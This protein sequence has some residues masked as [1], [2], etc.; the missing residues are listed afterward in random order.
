[1]FSLN[2]ANSVTKNCH[3]SK[4]ARNWPLSHLLCK[5]PGCYH[6]ASKTH[7]RDSIFEFSLIH[8]SVVISF[9]EFTNSVKVLLYLGKTLLS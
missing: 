4:R 1:M 5:R 2:S 8:T 9:P 6:T 3:Y 7:V